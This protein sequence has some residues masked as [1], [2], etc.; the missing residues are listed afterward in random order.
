MEGQA[1]LICVP[2]P[3]VPG[4]CP[5]KPS[6]ITCFLLP[7]LLTESAGTS[8]FLWRAVSL[9]LKDSM[10]IAITGLQTYLS[11]MC[12]PAG[13]DHPGAFPTPLSTC[14][15]HVVSLLHGIQEGHWPGLTF[16]LLFLARGDGGQADGFKAW[17]VE[18]VCDFYTAYR[19]ELEGPAARPPL[20]SL[21]SGARREEAG[22]CGVTPGC[23]E[24]AGDVSPLS[25]NGDRPVLSIP[26]PHKARPRPECQAND[27]VRY[28]LAPP[29]SC[30][31]DSFGSVTP[32]VPQ[33]HSGYSHN[34]LTLRL[35][36]I[37]KHMRKHKSSQ[38]S[39][40]NIYR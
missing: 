36:F 25:P 2:G 33:L 6:P 14:Q 18:K 31:E 5:C 4:R 38:Q 19:K 35:P 39:L 27:R 12:P 15:P 20:P 1:G 26:L 7:L 21:H 37:D 8:A 40:I 28:S 3:L 30:R 13:V 32:T 10:Y 29:E 23:A 16:G 22:E 17:L 34:N 11:A 9:P 24:R